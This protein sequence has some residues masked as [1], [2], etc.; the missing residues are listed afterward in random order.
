MAA[1]KG[2][3]GLLPTGVLTQFLIVGTLS[4]AARVSSGHSCWL[5]SAE[6]LGGRKG[7]T[8]NEIFIL[9][10]GWLLLKAHV[11]PRMSPARLPGKR[12]VIPISE[13]GEPDMVVLACYP[14]TCEA[15][16]RGLLGIWDQ[17]GLARQF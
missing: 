10:S 5:S 9:A 16:A 2:S 14:S 1:R 17:S 7:G 12:L 11:S 15:E 3:S 13:E 4:R 8:K 6:G